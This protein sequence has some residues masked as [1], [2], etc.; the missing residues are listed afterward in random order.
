MRR[1]PCGIV[2]LISGPNRANVWIQGVDEYFSLAIL[3]RITEVCPEP[4]EGPI[5]HGLPLK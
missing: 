5:I 2:N 3:T 4:Q 1:S